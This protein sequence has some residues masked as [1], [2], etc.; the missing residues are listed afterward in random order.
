MADPNTEDKNRELPFFL[1]GTL[2]KG[3]CGGGRRSRPTS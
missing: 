1:Y 2:R 3:E